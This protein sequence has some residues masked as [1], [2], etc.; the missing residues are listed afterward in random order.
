MGVF[1]GGGGAT[2]EIAWL[3][4]VKNYAVRSSPPPLS[5]SWP[6]L[7]MAAASALMEI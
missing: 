3:W 6:R 5:L 2:A 7:L 4:P 1:G